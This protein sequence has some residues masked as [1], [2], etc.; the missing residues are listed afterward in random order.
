MTTPRRLGRGTPSCSPSS[1]TALNRRRRGHRRETDGPAP[2]SGCRCPASVCRVDPRLPRST[3]RWDGRAATP[4]IDDG[5]VHDDHARLG[6]VR[7][8]DDGDALRAVARDG[9]SLQRGDD[10]GRCARRRRGPGRP[11]PGRGGRLQRRGAGGHRRS[12]RRDE[13][14]VRRLLRDRGGFEGGGG[15]VGQPAA[16][17]CRY[18]VRGPPVPGI[19][20]FPQ[21]NEWITKERAG[22][23]RTGQL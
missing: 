10:P 9:G 5:E 2:S 6:R 20:E 15:R 22:R 17:G 14:A 11:D 8:K 18:E 3:L 21:D 4:E 19:D 7:G 13:G 12:V 23:E 1:R 16:G